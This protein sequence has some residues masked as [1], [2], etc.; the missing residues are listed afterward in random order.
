MC[1]YLG[2]INDKRCY[3]LVTKTAK[4]H[5]ISIGNEGVVVDKVPPSFP[6]EMK[7]TFEIYPPSNVLYILNILYI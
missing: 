5:K 3:L 6:T 7:K 1:S 4:N 2:G